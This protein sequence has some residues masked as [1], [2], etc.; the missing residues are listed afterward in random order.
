MSGISPFAS[1]NDAE[2]LANVAAG[3]WNFDDASW[4]NVSD[5]AKDF[6]SRLMLKD[7]RF[8]S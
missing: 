3:D 6:I 4:N 1:A 5:M 8:V 7:K 2:T